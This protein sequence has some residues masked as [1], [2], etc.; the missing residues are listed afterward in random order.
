MTDGFS[1]TPRGRGRFN[2][3]GKPARYKNVTTTL[4]DQEFQRL[5]EWIN[6]QPEP[7]PRRSEALRE[8]VLSALAISEKP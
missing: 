8:L 5:M 3:P 6:R 7:K 4:S 2:P 1:K